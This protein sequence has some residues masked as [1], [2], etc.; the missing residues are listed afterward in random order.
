MFFTRTSAQRREMMQSI[1][2]ESF[3]QAVLRDM[4]K[5]GVGSPARKDN[6]HETQSESHSSQEFYHSRTE[7]GIVR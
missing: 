5:A 3:A 7:A 2:I 6:E 4:K 1:N